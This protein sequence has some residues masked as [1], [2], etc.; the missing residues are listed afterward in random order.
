MYL[1]KTT[2]VIIMIRNFDQRLKSCEIVAVLFQNDLCLY[3]TKK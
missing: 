1:I 3:L 2:E